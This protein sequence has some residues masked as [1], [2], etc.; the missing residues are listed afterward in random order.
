MAGPLSTD[1]TSYQTVWHGST[2]YVGSPASG[3]LAGHIDWAV[4]APGVFP[5]G[6]AGY[7]PSPP[8]Y[9]YA[10]QGFET[11]P[12]ALTSVSVVL[13]NFADHIGDFTATG[14]SGQASISSLLLPFDSSNWSFNGVPQ[15]GSTEGLVFFSPNTPEMT[16]ATTIDHGTVGLALPVPSPSST[17]IPEPSTLVLAMCGLVGF[18]ILRLRRPRLR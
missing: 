10:Y 12:A 9:L 16:E 6:Y 11:G 18:A 1:T 7:V 8:E 14:I 15:S 3:G 17:N 2:T 4:Y 5:A 13:D